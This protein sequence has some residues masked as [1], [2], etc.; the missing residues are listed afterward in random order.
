MAPPLKLL[1]V[2]RQDLERSRVHPAVAAAR[3]VVYD[4]LTEQ[5]D[6]LDWLSPTVIHA[7]N[8]IENN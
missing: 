4:E 2:A 8:Q 6:G 5:A 7:T 3:N 1:G